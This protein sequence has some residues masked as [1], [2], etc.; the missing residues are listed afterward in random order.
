MAS[1]RLA[2]SEIDP[3]APML[4]N[5]V[6]TQCNFVEQTLARIHSLAYTTFILLSPQRTMP[7]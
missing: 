7:C 4:E 6:F 5:S 2:K 1:F 3:E